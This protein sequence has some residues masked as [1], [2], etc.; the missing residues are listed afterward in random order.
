MYLRLQAYLQPRLHR[1]RQRIHLLD[2]L[3]RL[4]YPDPDILNRLQYPDYLI[5]M[6]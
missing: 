6:N 5:H 1:H 2:P 3:H 4:G